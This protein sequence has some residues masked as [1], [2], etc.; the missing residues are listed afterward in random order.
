MVRALIGLKSV[1]GDFQI[2]IWIK[3][4]GGFSV[5]NGHFS[6]KS[7]NVS[8]FRR[9]SARVT[10]IVGISRSG[11]TTYHRVLIENNFLEF[12]NPDQRAPP[13]TAVASSCKMLH[14]QAH[15]A[16]LRE[17]RRVTTERLCCHTLTIALRVYSSIL[18]TLRSFTS[19]WKG[20]CLFYSMIVTLKV[21]TKYYRFIQS[22]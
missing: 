9:Y 17:T 3:S 4:S 21:Q 2:S 1:M 16:V 12:F 11:L 14:E 15:S 22:K 13:E 6:E 20:K 19:Y 10:Y 7:Q 5:K 8:R 18:Y